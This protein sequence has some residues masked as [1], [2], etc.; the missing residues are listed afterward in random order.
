MIKFKN[1]VGWTV[2]RISAAECYSF[3]GLAICDDCNTFCPKG[4]YLVPV[5]N[6]FMCDK[7]YNDWNNR[8]KFYPEDLDFENSIIKYYENILPVTVSNTPV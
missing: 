3:G 1:K 6:H 5:L 8:C 2:Y 4:G 7:C